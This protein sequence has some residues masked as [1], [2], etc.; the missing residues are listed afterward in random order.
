MFKES[1]FILKHGK[2]VPDREFNHNCAP[3]GTI[4]VQSD[5]D[6]VLLDPVLMS[7]SGG[8]DNSF[9][10]I[11]SGSEDSN[12]GSSSILADVDSECHVAKSG[13]TSSGDVFGSCED[14]DSLFGS[15]GTIHMEFKECKRNVRNQSRIRTG[16]KK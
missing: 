11:E 2:K 15:K 14:V 7:W 1:D 5:D 4:P 3:V 9:E 12:S 10:A 6:V 16:P 8:S 13:E